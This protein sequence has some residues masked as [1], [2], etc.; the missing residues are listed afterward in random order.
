MKKEYFISTPY[1][2]AYQTSER[3][4]GFT[5]IDFDEFHKKMESQCYSWGEQGLG[6]ALLLG[7]EIPKCGDHYV[8]AF[9]RFGEK[10]YMMVT[11]QPYEDD[12]LIV[13]GFWDLEWDVT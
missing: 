12:L 3:Y 11:F 9:G 8:L 4:N 10:Y 7:K 1:I 6:R 13:E 5:L 2:D